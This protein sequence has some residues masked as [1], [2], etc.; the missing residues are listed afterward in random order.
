VPT[1]GDAALGGDDFD[2][3]LA[4]WAL[5]QSGLV[6]S[7][8]QDKRRLLVAARRAKEALTDAD[9]TWL[10]AALEAGELRVRVDRAG[11][12]TL[13][14]PLVARTLSSVKRVLRD[15]KLRPAEVQGCVMVGGST[16]MPCVRA[17]VSQ[18]F[19]REVL[20]NLNPDEVVALGAAIQANQL[21]GNAANGEILLLDVIPLSLGLETMGGLVERIIERNATIPVAKAQDFT[22]FKDGQTALALHVVQGERELVSECRSLARFELRGIPPMA[23]GAARIRVTFQVDADGLLSVSAQEMIS[24]VQAAI[25]VK[26]SYG[27]ADD[28]IAAMLQDGFAS[29]ERDMDARKLREAR[30]E[31]ERMV[32][33][34]RSAL[35]ADGDL[36]PEPERAQLEQQLSALAAMTDD[37]DRIEAATKALA[38]AT[39]GF[40]AERMNR[41]IARAL[42]GR[43]LNS[44]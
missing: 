21:A 3:L 20:T 35:A 42:A 15:A 38:E 32:L 14:A 4:D 31:A 34:T 24:G 37:A 6:A 29:A 12:D 22:T 8:A 41:S 13:V 9:E 5:A 27:L 30:V 19:G 1:G 28:Q 11:F 16:R 23:A 43:D 39:E 44:L 17:A 40:A 18:L 26:P 7:T 33:A 36:L 2:R 25:T 10:T